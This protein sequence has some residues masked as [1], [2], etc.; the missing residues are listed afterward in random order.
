VSPT[1]PVS[2]VPHG[3]TNCVTRAVRGSDPGAARVSGQS[4]GL[5]SESAVAQG[6][7]PTRSHDI[8]RV[9]RCPAQLQPPKGA[10]SGP[11]HPPPSDWVRRLEVSGD[12][13]KRAARATRRV[14]GRLRAAESCDR[15]ALSGHARPGSLHAG[16]RGNRYPV[17]LGILQILKRSA[18][19]CLPALA[20][21]RLFVRA[22]AGPFDGRRRSAAHRHGRYVRAGS[23]L[24]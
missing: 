4:E 20:V 8:S 21:P 16:R 14:A 7:H 10:P 12:H 1:C 22:P 2:I 23:L 18:L 5:Q 13:G 15:V 11:S 9:S 3:S 17:P 6:E 19:H 24:R